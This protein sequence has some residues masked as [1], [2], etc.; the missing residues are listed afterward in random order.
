MDKKIQQQIEE[1]K[2]KTGYTICEIPKVSEAQLFDA[3]VGNYKGKVVFVDFW[4]TWCGPCRAA[5]R[6]T[7]P[8][9]DAELKSDNLVFVYLTGPSSP[10][11][12][13]LTM[14]ADIKGEH[15]RLSDKQWTYICNK[16]KI[17][18]IPSYVL[19]DRNGNYE[20]RNDLRNHD[21]LKNT[22]LKAIK[23]S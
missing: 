7:E 22:L 12:K 8:L 21:T 9:K 5:M 3:I 11:T 14:I 17:D 16:F 19:V 6:Q 1:S 18:G 13:W 10:E 2:S 4:A 15:Y 23:N 20:L